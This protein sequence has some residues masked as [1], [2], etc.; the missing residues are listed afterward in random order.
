MTFALL[1]TDRTCTLECYRGKMCQKKPHGRH[2]ERVDD[3]KKKKFKSFEM[4][5]CSSIYIF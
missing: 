3:V 1:A 2:L 4:V 5:V